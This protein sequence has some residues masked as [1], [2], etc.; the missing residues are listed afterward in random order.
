M[1]GLKYVI[2]FRIHRGEA[3][4]LL[5]VMVLCQHLLWCWTEHVCHLMW[6]SSNSLHLMVCPYDDFSISKSML[7]ASLWLQS[8]HPI[9]KPS[10]PVITRWPKTAKCWC[11]VS[12][13][14]SLP[15]FSW[16]YEGVKAC[17]AVSSAVSAGTL[18]RSWQWVFISS[19]INHNRISSWYGCNTAE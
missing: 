17:R 19:T 15:L 11:S 9:Q 14:L 7:A 16:L 2:L 3:P 1:P 4:S 12:V 13:F 5:L 6:E 18:L 10:L 8:M